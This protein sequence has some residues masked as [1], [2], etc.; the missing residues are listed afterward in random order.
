MRVRKEKRPLNDEAAWRTD[1]AWLRNARG[2][3]N[4]GGRWSSVPVIRRLL[5]CGAVYYTG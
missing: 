4:S 2:W 3:I 1:S 5:E